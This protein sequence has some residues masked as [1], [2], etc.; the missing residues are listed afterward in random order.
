MA[1]RFHEASAIP[2]YAGVDGHLQGVSDQAG[3]HV[4]GYDPAHHAAGQSMTVA[5]L[6][7]CTT[8]TQAY[9]LD[10]ANAV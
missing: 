3:A 9:V 4:V 5:I 1:A 6:W 2:D 7:T 8:I 10:E